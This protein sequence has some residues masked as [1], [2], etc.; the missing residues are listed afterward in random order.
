MEA[1]KRCF[2]SFLFFQKH[3][4]KTYNNLLDKI[5]I[6]IKNFCTVKKNQKKKWLEK[7]LNVLNHIQ[8]QEQLVMLI[9]EKQER[10]LIF[11][12][13]HQPFKGGIQMQT[14]QKD[15]V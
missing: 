9:M 5:N 4:F 2:G 10:L 14:F 7:N 6:N 11:S 1:W 8:I 15:F 13:L 3:R 12:I